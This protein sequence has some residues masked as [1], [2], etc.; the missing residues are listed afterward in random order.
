MDDK[1][2]RLQ[3]G[4]GYGRPNQGKRYRSKT[5]NCALKGW[6]ELLTSLQDRSEHV[7]KKSVGSA[8]ECSTTLLSR[9]TRG[10]PSAAKEMLG[11]HTVTGHFFSTLEGS[12][13]GLR[14]CL[15]G[16]RGAGKGLS[17][18]VSWSL[19]TSK[20]GLE[21]T[22]RVAQEIIGLNGNFASLRMCAPAGPART[23]AAL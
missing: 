22:D 23:D 16:N 7:L 12:Y 20:G 11:Q 2:A 5:P 18:R 4:Q 9:D 6:N 10:P 13:L 8:A 15:Q 1:I 3:S 19:T 17:R 14:S 21:A